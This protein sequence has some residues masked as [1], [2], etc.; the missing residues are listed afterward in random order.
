MPEIKLK[1]EK[2][3]VRE[4]E[5]IADLARIEFS[6]EEKIKYAEDLSAVLNYIDQLSEVNTDNV[7]AASNAAGLVNAV[8]EDIVENC[9]EETKK[10]ILDGAP[11][12]EGDYIKV[13][14]VL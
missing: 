1:K 10:K 2:L 11:A 7:L 6:E 9:G 8:R 14:A 13:K 12:R 5:H 3:S 4:A